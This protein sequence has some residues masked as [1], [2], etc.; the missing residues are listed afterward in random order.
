MLSTI[1]DYLTL[2]VLTAEQLE[3]HKNQI[4]WVVS[5]TRYQYLQEQGK[6]IPY[7]RK[8]SFALVFAIYSLLW[9][10]TIPIFFSDAKNPDEDFRLTSEE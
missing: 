10:I 1:I 7:D 2:G 4:S 9:P 5:S 6:E 8:Y 3:T